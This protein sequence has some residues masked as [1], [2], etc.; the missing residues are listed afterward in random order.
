MSLLLTACGSSNT[1][2]IDTVVEDLGSTKIVATK[3]ECTSR[4]GSGHAATIMFFGEDIKNMIATT[5]EVQKKDG[6]AIMQDTDITFDVWKA[7]GVNEGECL[8]NITVHIDGGTNHRAQIAI[9]NYLDTPS[10]GQGVLVRTGQLDVR[11]K[12]DNF[13]DI[14]ESDGRSMIW[15]NFTGMPNTSRLMSS[16]R[17]VSGQH[18]AIYFTG[19]GDNAEANIQ[20]FKNDGT[21]VGVAKQQIGKNSA[22]ITDDVKSLSYIDSNGDKVTSLPSDGEAYLKIL[23]STDSET[24]ASCM[25]LYSESTANTVGGAWSNSKLPQSTLTFARRNGGNDPLS[26][27]Q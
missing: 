12:F 5:N 24:E 8:G 27:T 4:S 14:N 23:G 15:N 1:D 2:P 9:E 11:K 6:V 25:V 19:S 21:Y 26:L 10:F 3:G 13:I 22:V 17:F 16:M 18:L 7:N 20:L